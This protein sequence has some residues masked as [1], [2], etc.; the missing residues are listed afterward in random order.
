MDLWHGLAPLVRQADPT[1]Y[2]CVLEALEQELP[3]QVLV[4]YV[5]RECVRALEK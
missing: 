2:Q 5:H 3:F 4:A 1:R